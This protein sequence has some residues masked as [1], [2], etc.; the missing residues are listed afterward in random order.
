MEINFNYT[1]LSARKKLP[2]DEA[3]Y[4]VICQNRILYIGTT[5][6]LRH[7]FSKHSLANC[8]SNFKNIYIVWFWKKDTGLERELIRIFKPLLNKNR[9]L[10]SIYKHKINKKKKVL[11]GVPADI[12]DF[13]GALKILGISQAT[14]ISWE[15]N[16]EIN[17]HKAVYQGRYRKCYFVAELKKLAK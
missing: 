4:F 15:N 14:L 10:N 12:T 11:E 16:G 13:R 2:R 9:P 5:T 1:A 17:Y 6:D 7:R 8:F 3:I